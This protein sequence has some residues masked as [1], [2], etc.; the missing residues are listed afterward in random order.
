MAVIGLTPHTKPAPMRRP[1]NV[2]SS[3]VFTIP[4]P[5]LPEVRVEEYFITVSGEED[6]SHVTNIALLGLLPLFANDDEECS[7]PV[8]L[9]ETQNQ[10]FS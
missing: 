4:H 9:A 7:R 3:L 10:L 8:E 2:V 6:W 5:V 1:R